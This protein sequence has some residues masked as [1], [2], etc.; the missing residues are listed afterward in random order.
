M[1]EDAE[2]VKVRR[3]AG[4]AS[5]VEAETLISAL[6]EDEWAAALALAERWV[7]LDYL[8]IDGDVKIN[9]QQERDG[10]RHELRTLLGLDVFSDEERGPGYFESCAVPVEAW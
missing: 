5:R 8:V 10:I 2:V 6:N 1:T 4:L 3:A 7:A 9:P